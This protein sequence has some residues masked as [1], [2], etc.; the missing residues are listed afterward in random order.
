MFDEDRRLRALLHG[1]RWWL[2]DGGARME[3]RAL[4][5]PGDL[6][7]GKPAHWNLVRPRGGF[8]PGPDA[9]L[10]AG[11]TLLVLEAKRGDVKSPTRERRRAVYEAWGYALQLAA[12]LRGERPTLYVSGERDSAVALAELAG[13]SN[14][15]LARATVVPALVELVERPAPTRLSF[16]AASTALSRGELPVRP[17]PLKLAWQRA[18]D[19]RGGPGEFRWAAADAVMST[20]ASVLLTLCGQ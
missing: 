12:N 10:I 6:V 3:L 13:I 19:W 15:E 5:P 11:R 14:K 7:D 1:A 17:G 18:L 4:V 20:S 16:E 2:D 9:L 8:T